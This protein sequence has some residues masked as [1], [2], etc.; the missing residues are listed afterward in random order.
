MQAIQVAYAMHFNRQH[1]HRGHLFQERFTSWVIEN[2]R[3]LLEAKEY[4]ESNP[5]KAGIVT[6]K[7][8]YTW[9]S[10]SR[11]SSPI[12]LSQIML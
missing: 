8:D 5:I 9:S 7:E 3:H 2:E 12:T 4:I 1:K 6:K 11:D 10:A